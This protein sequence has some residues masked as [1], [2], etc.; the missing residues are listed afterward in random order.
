MKRIPTFEQF[1]N[2]KVYRLSGF[3]S[4]K[5]FLGKIFQAFKKEI[6]GIKYEGDGAG[7]IEEVNK[8]WEKFQDDAKKMILINKLQIS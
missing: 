4:Q 6:Q 8:A 3:Y 2:E 5:G 7:T 1:V